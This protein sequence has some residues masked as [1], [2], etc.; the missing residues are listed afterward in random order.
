MVVIYLRIIE[1][2]KVAVIDDEIYCVDVMET[3]LENNFPKINAV[4][5]FTNP[6]EAVKEIPFLDIDI[7]FC[8]ISMPELS[9]FEVLDKLMPFSFKVVFTTAYDNHA[10]RALR[11]GALDYLLKPISAEDLK[12]C[13][14][15]VLPSIIRD[16]KENENLGKKHQKIC[17]TNSDGIIFIPLKDITYCQSESNYT[18]FYLL[19]GK[20]IITS[21][22]MKEFE[23][24]LE[25]N[26]FYRI[27]NSFIINLNFVEMVVKG[28]GG[29]IIVN[30][31][32]IPI[33]RTKRP[34]ILDVLK[35]YHE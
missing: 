33:S 32:K 7:L 30:G 31:A 24:V 26:G 3:L 20:K 19:N 35:R 18:T 11:Y 27:H 10:I 14:L 16:K 4:K 34:E 17:V 29:S 23:Q 1:M 8:D 22:T 15:N 13:L 5:S 12:D 25:C 28:D 6:I 9:G 2:I 21:K